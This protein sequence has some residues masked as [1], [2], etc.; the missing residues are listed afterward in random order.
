MRVLFTMPKDQ[1]E[2][3]LYLKA[4][5]G[6]EKSFVHFDD[7][8]VIPF[9]GIAATEHHFYEDFENI[10]EGI[11]PFIMASTSSRVHLSEKN[12]GYTKDVLSGNFSLKIS[13]SNPNGLMAQTLPSG[14]R[15]QPNKTHTISFDYQ[16]DQPDAYSVKVKRIKGGDETVLV[17]EFLNKTGKFKRTFTTSDK[18]DYSIFLYKHDSKGDSE[19]IIDELTVD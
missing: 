7:V 10:D 12:E 18:Q 14:L 4:S 6:S 8:R 19:L 17:D 9:Y 15:F 1:T 16:V 2:A 13:S 11:Y 5:S 3:S